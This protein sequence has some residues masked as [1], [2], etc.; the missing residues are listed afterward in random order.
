MDISD[1][2]NP[3]NDAQREAVTSPEP[4]VLVLA[5]AGS[6]KTRV[7]VHRIAWLMQV[8]SLSAHRL[9]AVTF[10][11][12]AAAEMRHRI[13][14]LLGAPPHSL[15]IGTFHGIANR[16]LRAHASVADLPENFQIL[17][18]DDQLRLIRR[19]MKELELDESAFAPRQLQWLINAHKDEGRRAGFLPDSTD[20][21]DAALKKLYLAY[22][23]FCRRTGLVD[24]AELLLRAHELLRDHPELLDHYQARFRYVLVDEFQDTNAIQYAWLNLLTRDQQNLTVVGDDDQ[25][26]YG[27]RG[28]KVENLRRY[29][30]D[31]PHHRLIRLEQNY[32]S[33]G[34]ILQAANALIEKNAGRLGKSLWTSLGNGETISVFQAFNEQEEAYFAVERIQQWVAD[35]GRRSDAA[36]LYRSNA[37]SRQF[38][39]KLLAKGIPYR[40][41]GGMRFFERVEIKDALAYLRLISHW[42]DDSAFERV[43]NTPARGI[44]P[45]TLDILRQQ[46]R[47]EGISLWQASEAVCAS[48]M[49]PA[50]ARTALG[51]FLELIRQLEQQLLSF[52]DLGSQVRVAV[53]GSGLA[54][55]YRKEKGE[56]AEAR[57]ENLEE[58]AGAARQF[59][60]EPTQDESGTRL[61][62]F[63]AHAALESGDNQA[64]AY[65]DSV[66][67]MTLHTAKGLEFD[68]VFLVGMEEGLFPGARSMEDAERLEEERRLCYVGITRARRKLFMTYAECR[69][70]YGKETY[71]RSSRFLRELPMEC[72]DEVRLRSLDR[73]SGGA[74]GSGAMSVAPAATASGHGLRAGLRVFHERFGEGVILQVEGDGAQLR[75]QVNFRDAGMKWLMM[76]YARLQIL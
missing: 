31:Y 70:L 71:P 33:T 66:Q 49:L 47:Q 54:D 2:L 5:G 40:V 69:R 24:F 21:V 22:E 6:G 64:D 67:L 44:G 38:E 53:E 73:R 55:H 19:L 26:I 10:T 72:L 62:Q 43:I 41:F 35:G 48:G 58:L 17:D 34:H 16:L 27:W 65:E 8:E 18:A 45:R 11:N 25:S 50:R 29:Q 30:S 15:W 9:L 14:A 63:L 60:L 4:A 46:A 42:H 7:L 74:S 28:A 20:P 37:Q 57:L 36:I 76:A 39:E 12:K 52:S 75:V 68:L 3:L 1:I 32:R 56:Q 51:G 61:D 59:D 23:G 13:G